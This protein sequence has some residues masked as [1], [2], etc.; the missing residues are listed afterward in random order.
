MVTYEDCLA[1]AGLTAEEVDLI[2][3]RERLP[4]IVA[5]ELTGHLLE[6]TEGRR[7]LRRILGE[8]NG[9]AQVC[10]GGRGDAIPGITPREAKRLAA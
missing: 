2:A 1:L 6:T 4:R 5:L 3:A 7:R 9:A 10:D 8:D